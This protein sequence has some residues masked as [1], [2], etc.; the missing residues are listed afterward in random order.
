[1]EQRE[2]SSLGCPGNSQ[3]I[4]KGALAALISREEPKKLTKHESIPIFLLH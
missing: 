2:G 1:V 4:E 3:Q